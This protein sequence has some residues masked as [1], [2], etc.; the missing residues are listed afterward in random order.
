M[1]CILTYRCTLSYIADQHLLDNLFA[2]KHHQ[3]ICLK[4]ALILISSFQFLQGMTVFKIH[5]PE[6]LLIFSGPALDE[7]AVEPERLDCM[8]DGGATPQT[9]VDEAGCCWET[10]AH[11]KCFYS[12]YEGKHLYV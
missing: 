4:L 10:G 5:L 2:G 11:T 7:C 1:Q 12:N 8:P 9:C 3:N 6:T